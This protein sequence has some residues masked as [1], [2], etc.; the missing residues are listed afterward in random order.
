MAMSG[1]HYAIG[2]LLRMNSS[3]HKPRCNTHQKEALQWAPW[4]APKGLLYKP[5]YVVASIGW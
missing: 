2:S 5:K 4:H 3:Y 1:L